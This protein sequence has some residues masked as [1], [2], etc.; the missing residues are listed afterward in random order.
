MTYTIDE[1]YTFIIV[2]VYISVSVKNYCIV[3]SV[4]FV[5]NSM[6]YVVNNVKIGS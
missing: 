1:F 2:V 6:P 4:N 3:Q 5:I